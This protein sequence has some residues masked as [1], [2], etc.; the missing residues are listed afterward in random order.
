M[1]LKPYRE[2][3]ALMTK[4]VII[5]DEQENPTIFIKGPRHSMDLLEKQVYHESSIFKD[6]K[7]LDLSSFFRWHGLLFR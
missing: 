4:W 3:G 2:A 6:S 1:C 5:I 7:I